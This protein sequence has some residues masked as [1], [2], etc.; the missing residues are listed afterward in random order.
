MFVIDRE[1]VIAVRQA[2][3][4]EGRERA[5]AVICDRWRGLDR[6]A[7]LLT[8]DEVMCWRVD[9]SERRTSDL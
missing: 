2:F 4:R 8:V 9:L 3:L 6:A 1:T 5:A 7:A